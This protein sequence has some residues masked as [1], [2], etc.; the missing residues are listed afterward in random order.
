MRQNHAR[1]ETVSLRRRDVRQA[2]CFSAVSLSLRLV[3]RGLARGERLER[4]RE[5][6]DAGACCGD[7]DQEHQHTQGKEDE[8]DLGGWWQLLEFLYSGS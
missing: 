1:G 6:Q 4:D 5:R 2:P 3:R 8:H 7:Q